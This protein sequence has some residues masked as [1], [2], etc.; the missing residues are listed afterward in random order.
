V[1]DARTSLMKGVAS[2]V[3]RLFKRS[4]HPFPAPTG[5]RTGAMTY[6][7]RSTSVTCAI[8]QR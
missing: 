2:S 8:F 6:L 5:P 1:P 3:R 7:I 4:D